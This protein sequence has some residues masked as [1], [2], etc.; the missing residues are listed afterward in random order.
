M[1][2]FLPVIKHGLL[3]NPRTKWR[4][5][6]G[7]STYNGELSWVSWK[8]PYKWRIFQQ[9]MVDY[10]RVTA[11]TPSTWKCSSNHEWIIKNYTYRT[12]I[13][14]I[15][16]ICLYVIYIYYISYIPISNL[17]CTPHPIP[18]PPTQCANLAFVYLESDTLEAQV[19][20]PTFSMAPWRGG[21]GFLPGKPED[22]NLKQWDSTRKRSG[23]KAYWN[24]DVIL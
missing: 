1:T 2:T 19:K 12:Y 20:C 17:N 10:R 16:T 11:G 4:I 5:S 14:Y 7:K 22:F 6:M 13:P 23:F 24:S 21:R 8:F 18:S 9:A 15:Y 3:E